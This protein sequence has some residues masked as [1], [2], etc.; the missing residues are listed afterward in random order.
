MS[1][2]NA[3]AGVVADDHDDDDDIEYGP[4]QSNRRANQIKSDYEADLDYEEED[5]NIK[6]SRLSETES[7]EVVQLRQEIQL[8]DKFK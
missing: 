3:T 2:S 7:I 8:L 5:N 6:T 1:S 4:V